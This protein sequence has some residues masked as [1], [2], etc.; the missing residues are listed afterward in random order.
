M[1]DKADDNDA[2]NMLK[3]FQKMSEKMADS[4]GLRIKVIRFRGECLISSQNHHP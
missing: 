1:K 3:S 4:K 2:I